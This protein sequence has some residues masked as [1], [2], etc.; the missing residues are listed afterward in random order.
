MNWDRFLA[1]NSLALIT[2][3]LLQPLD[4]VKVRSQMLQEGKIYTG[5]GFG[6][7]FHPFQIFD[8]IHRSGRGIA[9]MY[10]GFD[11]FVARTI[12]YTTARV[13]GFLYFYDWLNADPRRNARIDWMIMS[14][15]A[16]GA[17][18][19]VVTNPIELVY[20]RMQAEDMYPE[21]YRR[22]Y[23]SFV[24]GLIKAADE[25]VL[26]RGA[27]ANA[28]R[29]GVLACSMTGIYDWCKENSYFF[30]GPHWINR[31]WATGAAVVCG[32][33]ASMPFDAVRTRMHTMR[34]LPNG[35]LPYW[36]SWDCFKK[37][38][39]YES[40][41]RFASNFG[42]SFYAGAQAYGARL[43]GICYLSQY[44]LDTYLP[45]HYQSEFWQPSR[46]QYQ[47]GLDYDIHDPYTDAYI[48]NYM[49]STSPGM[50]GKKQNQHMPQAGKPLR[51]V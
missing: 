18:A 47:G 34:P 15:L 49:H 5:V 42:G 6:R 1:A 7:G 27:P 3:G 48:T 36:S 37:M 16:G 22:N 19:G 24:D 12:A 40:A 14:S 25:G 39:H 26:L 50:T 23:T 20:T 41:P 38:C 44:M 46:F 43:F 31:L 29:I 21:Q 4:L 30:F 45:N 9:S 33:A 51:T 10:S 17:I 13:W 8:E 32:V 11:G 35:N 28:L 2:H